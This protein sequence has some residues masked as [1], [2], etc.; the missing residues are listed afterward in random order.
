MFNVVVTRFLVRGRGAFAPGRP[1]NTRSDVCGRRATLAIAD[2]LSWAMANVPYLAEACH[3]NQQ[4]AK[5]RLDPVRNQRVRR[6]Q[7]LDIADVEVLFLQE[8][9]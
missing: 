7:L 4:S 8:L 2:L 9:L 6:D 3:H 5:R 1:N